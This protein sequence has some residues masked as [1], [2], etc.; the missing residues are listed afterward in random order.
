MELRLDRL[1]PDVNR[2]T[3]FLLAISIVPILGFDRCK[4]CFRQFCGTFK[5]HAYSL[6]VR[7]RHEVSC[8]VYCHRYYP[9]EDV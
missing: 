9:N 7:W 5:G 6:V 8:V 2:G 4:K 3:G 1:K